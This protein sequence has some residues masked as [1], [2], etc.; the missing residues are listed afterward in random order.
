MEFEFQ[1]S[2]VRKDFVGSTH[3]TYGNAM[4]QMADREDRLAQINDLKLLAHAPS[5]KPSNQ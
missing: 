4:E 1:A 5:S 3:R 2:S